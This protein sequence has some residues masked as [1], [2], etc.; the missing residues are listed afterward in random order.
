MRVQQE[1]ILKVNQRYSHKWSGYLLAAVTVVSAAACGGS[2]THFYSKWPGTAQP[3][4]L[5]GMR[6]ATVFIT[7]NVSVR[8]QGEEV[9]ARE[10][11]RIGGVGVASYTILPDNPQDRERA[12]RELEKA[13]ADVVLSMRVVSSERMTTYTPDYFIGSPHYR[14]LWGYWGYGWGGV[15]DPG[16]LRTSTV[17]AVETILYSLKDEKMLWAG[18]S[19]TFDKDNVKS[20]VKSI[21]REAV[22][23]MSDDGVLITPN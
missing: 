3:V 19:E 8:R 7:D 18:M 22:D 16:Y 4:S 15:Y 14:S 1:V 10:V 20:A 6:V 23:E 11:T 2:S 5:T 17:V 13:G 12:Q 9:M 21:A